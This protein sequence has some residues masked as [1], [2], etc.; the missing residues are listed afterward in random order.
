MVRTGKDVFRWSELHDAAEIE[1]G[2]LVREVPDHGKIVRDE[3]VADVFLRLQV[4]V[5]G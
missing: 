5:A 1:H 3:D 4:G 2:D